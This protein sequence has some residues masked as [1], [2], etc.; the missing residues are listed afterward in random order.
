MN[1][2]LLACIT[3]SALVSV[4]QAAPESGAASGPLRLT[5]PQMDTVTA[6]TASTWIASAASGLQLSGL[7]GF[8]H[9]TNMNPSP[10]Y[11]AGICCSP[12]ANIQLVFKISGNDLLSRSL[13]SSGVIISSPEGVTISSSETIFERNIQIQ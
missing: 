6:G 9:T 2:D 12:D 3:L 7:N 10:N 8:N 4:A 11:Y 5:A 1:V 13:G